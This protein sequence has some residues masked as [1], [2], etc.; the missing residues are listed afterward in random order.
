MRWPHMTLRH[1]AHRVSL[2]TA[3]RGLTIPLPASWPVHGRS[4]L[5]SASALCP[6]G[7]VSDALRRKIWRNSF[8]TFSEQPMR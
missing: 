3:I 7:P 6:N 4:G 5:R 2:P 8:L 1:R